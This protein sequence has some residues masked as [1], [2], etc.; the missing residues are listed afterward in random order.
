M[1]TDGGCADDLDRYKMWWV[2]VRLLRRAKCLNKKVM[3][4]IWD[5]APWHC[6]NRIRKWIR[7]YNQQAKQLGE[8]RLLVHWLPKQSPWLNPIEPFWGHAKRRVCEP[9]G[10]LSMAELKRRIRAQFDALALD[11]LLQSPAPI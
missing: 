1:N 5:N 10:N 2:I 11:D 3:V 4:L 8:V 6:S 9:S 7:L